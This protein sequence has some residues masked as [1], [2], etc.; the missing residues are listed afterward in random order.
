MILE[1]IFEYF[2]FVLSVLILWT[3][4]LYRWKDDTDTVWLGCMLILAAAASVV[5][6]I[7]LPALILYFIA[8]ALADILRR[9]ME[10]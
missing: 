5:W 3:L 10:D 2:M 6:F 1:Q 4:I 8:D 7:T 9:H